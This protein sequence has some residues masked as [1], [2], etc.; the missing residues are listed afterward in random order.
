MASVEDKVVHPHE[1]QMLVLESRAR[2]K[3]MNC[4]RRW[5]KTRLA[6]KMMLQESRKQKQ[7]LWWVAPTYK[8]VKR[9][10]AEVLRQLPQGV[11]THSPPPETNFDSGRS[12]ILRF[13]NKTKME[14]YSAER[15]EGMLGEGVDFAVLDEAAIM[16]GRIWNQI[17]RPTLMDRKG[18]A[19][20]ISTPRGRNWFYKVWQMGQDPERDDWASWTF[21]SRDNPYLPPGEVEDMRKAMPRLEY[22]QEVLAEFL[23]SGSTTFLLPDECVQNSR[24]LPDF[25]VHGAPPVGQVCLGIDLA[26]TNDWTVIYGAR[27]RDRRNCY[28]E[29]MQALTWPEQK[30]RIRRA[31]STCYR[32]GAEHVML[33]MDSTGVGDPIV[34]DLEVEG[35]DVV[36]INFSTHKINMVRALAKDL[37]EV[38]AWILPDYMHEFTDYTM[39]MSEAGK[40]KYSAPEGEHDDVVSAKLL[41]HWGLV[42][43]G[44][45]ETTILSADGPGSEPLPSDD[46]VEDFSDLL[47]DSGP[48]LSEADAMEAVGLPH[49]DRPPTHEELLRRGWW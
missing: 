17:V 39:T 43:E 1:G 30:R 15:P 21:T 29:R 26:K 36:P 12:V 32:Q 8:V 5:G 20:M 3:V 18:G 19:L 37:E 44:V 33:M 27:A 22:E 35:Y 49:G 4:G 24:V 38:H 9:G 13:K 48:D 40:M 41:Q 28:F 2:F 31:V 23:A 47:D 7:M 6:A 46:P 45:P 34:D 25:T 42:T 11:L 14:F 16:P 10:Y